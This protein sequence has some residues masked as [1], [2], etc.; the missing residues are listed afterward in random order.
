LAE[1]LP[2]AFPT[3]GL[4][5]LR[6]HPTALHAALPSSSGSNR[7]ANAE[8]AINLAHFLQKYLQNLVDVSAYTVY[9]HA[10]MGFPLAAVLPS[11]QAG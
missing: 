4:P 3:T 5:R 9:I 8:R 10:D 1:K 6:Y 7:F 2:S 11:F